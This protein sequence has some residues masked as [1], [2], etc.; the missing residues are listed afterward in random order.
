MLLELLL[1]LLFGILAGTITGLLPG[2]HINLVGAILV[3]LS[4]GILSSI[5]PIYLVAFVV[6]MSITH[7]FTDFIPSVF[8]GCPDADTVLSVLPGAS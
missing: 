8:L 6:A 3:S 7:T 4:V 1:A 2:I 5:D